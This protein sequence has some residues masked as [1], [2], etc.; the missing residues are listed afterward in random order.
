MYRQ[1]ARKKL[2]TGV[3]VHS[4]AGQRKQSVIV[5]NSRI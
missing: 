5:I 4:A 1:M 3:E 2:S